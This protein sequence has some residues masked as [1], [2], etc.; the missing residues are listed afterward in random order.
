MGAMGKARAFFGY[1]RSSKGVNSENERGIMG[2]MERYEQVC[3][4]LTFTDTGIGKADLDFIRNEDAK[5]QIEHGLQTHSVY[6]WM[7]MLAER[8]LELSRAMMR[9]AFHSGSLEDVHTEAI[10]CAI[11]ALRIGVMAKES[12]QAG[13][14][15]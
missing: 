15:Q 12:A 3:K 9:A 2:F 4:E 13:G 7:I 6:Q 8:V 10:Q 14:G 11:L 5:H 1:V